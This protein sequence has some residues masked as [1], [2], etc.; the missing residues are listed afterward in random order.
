MGILGRLRRNKDKG[1]TP[2]E[3]ENNANLN[4]EGNAN[5][6]LQPIQPQQQLQNRQ[7]QQVETP[8]WSNVHHKD[9]EHGPETIYTKMQDD[10]NARGKERE[11]DYDLV[12]D[13]EDK[14][15]Y[16]VKQSRGYLSILFSLAQT[17]ILIA[18]MVQCKVA[19]ISINREFHE[20]NSDSMNYKEFLCTEYVILVVFVF[21]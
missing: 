4:V 11:E 14:P 13:D 21:D 6:K 8:Q 2:T 10:A 19:P 16:I 7:P 20:K 17:V 12:Y 3:E 9:A 15:I 1:R 18:M 5:A